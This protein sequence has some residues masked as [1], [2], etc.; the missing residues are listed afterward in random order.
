[1][2]Y[3]NYIVGSKINKRSDIQVNIPTFNGYEVTKNTIYKLQAQK[4]I[5]FDILVI[6]NA[7]EDYKKLQVDFPLINYVVLRE[8]TGGGGAQRIGIEI[9]LKYKY[10]FIVLTDNDAVLLDNGGL[11]EMA[12]SFS[13]ADV[14]GVVPQNIELSSSSTKGI[15]ELRGFFPLHYFFTR[16]SVLE[17]TGLHNFYM[18]LSGDDA[19]ITSKLLTAGR[20]LVNQDVLF[21]HPVFKPKN[22]QNK[23]TFL[24]TRSLLIL[25]FTENN[26]AIK[27]RIRAFLFICAL[28]TQ[29]LIHTIMLRDISYIKTL[30]YVATSFIYGYRNMNKFAE[31][32]KR[33]PENR[34]VLREVSPTAEDLKK[35]YSRNLF[36]LKNIIFLP[37][38]SCI[39]S[40]YEG[41]HIY[42]LL[43]RSGC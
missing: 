23:N 9:A 36:E 26:I 43:T 5:K 7:S 25:I 24:T 30:L 38:K 4:N 12:N 3:L 17:K 19:S 11:A 33:I 32:L 34:Y 28:L 8:N 2:N 42:F 18:F 13:N 40:K 35:N 29:S 16:V 21:Y 27:W 15:R 1:M 41:R 31:I 22:I 14:V 39:Y 37:R 20:V 10:N 6:D